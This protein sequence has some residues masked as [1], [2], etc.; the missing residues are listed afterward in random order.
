[1][2]SS[3][4]P[5]AIV[6]ALHGPPA[7]GKSTLAEARSRQ[8]AWPLLDKDDLKDV[9]DGQ[10]PQAGTLSYALLLRLVDRQLR[11]GV[12]VVCDS[13]LLERTYQGL[14][15]IAA[16]RN[17]RLAIVRCRC[18]DPAVWRQRIEARQG[19]GL[20]AHHSTT[21]TAVERFLAQPGVVYPIADACLEVDTLRPLAVL[22]AEI[23]PGLDQIAS[24]P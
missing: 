4:R 9:L 18:S 17:A 3:A 13:P 16:D 10:T 11:Q 14:R 24:P 2:P 20:P 12:S 6:L 15:A 1:M 5:S 23:L 19:Q 22:V 7:V 8:L 21:W